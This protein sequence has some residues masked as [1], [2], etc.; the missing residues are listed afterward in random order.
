MTKSEPSYPIKDWR[1]YFG[2]TFCNQCGGS[3]CPGCRYTG[4][5]MMDDMG[6]F[7]DE[8]IGDEVITDV[9]DEFYKGRVKK[10]LH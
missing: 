7:M 2:E 5:R 6:I 1:L 9:L 10:G 3:G 8:T 4:V